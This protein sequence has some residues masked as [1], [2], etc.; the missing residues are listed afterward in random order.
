MTL[1]TKR[2]LRLAA[3]ALTLTL[4]AG[5]AFAQKG[6]TVRIAWIDPLSG[7]MAPIGQ[8]QVRSFQ[9]L[10]EHFN[11]GNPAGVKFE[12]VTFDNKLSPAESQ[13]ALKAA[14]DQGIRYITQGD[15]SSVAGALV[16]AVNKHNERNP[17]QEVLFLNYAAV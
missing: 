1:T 16:D 7:L 3:P 15:G 11:R 4:L 14:V 17:G 13:N 6:E 8:N 2:A 9:Y 12:I 5:P 10:A